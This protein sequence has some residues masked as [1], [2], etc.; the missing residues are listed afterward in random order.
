MASAQVLAQN[1]PKGMG[2]EK[3]LKTWFVNPGMEFFW[4]T[5][6]DPVGA[7]NFHVKTCAFYR[8]KQQHKANKGMSRLAH[9]TCFV[10]RKQRVIRNVL[11]SNYAFKQA[12]RQGSKKPSGLQIA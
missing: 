6:P 12:K 1:P 3:G 9:I 8:K 2:V 4:P 11:I 10:E 7:P 5:R